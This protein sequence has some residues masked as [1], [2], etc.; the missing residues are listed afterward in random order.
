MTLTGSR[1]SLWG[2]EG[3]QS[4]ERGQERQGVFW[5]YE[6]QAFL[7]SLCAGGRASTIDLGFCGN[8]EGI[9]HCPLGKVKCGVSALEVGYR[10][11]GQTPAS[12]AATR[13]MVK[14]VLHNM[15]TS[16]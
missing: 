4:G 13:D 1:A 16:T 15:D 14:A 3:R 2:R 7:H 10:K 9:A 11:V 8:A 12:A 6:L 5:H